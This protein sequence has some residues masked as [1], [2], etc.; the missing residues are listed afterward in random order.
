M[1]ADL[2]YF[3]L[4]SFCSEMLR[5]DKKK[6]WEF[7]VVY[8]FDNHAIMLFVLCVKYWPIMGI[9]LDRYWQA[10]MQINSDIKTLWIFMLS[11]GRISV[12]YILLK[13]M[14]WK[15]YCILQPCGIKF[16]KFSPI[17]WQNSKVVRKVDI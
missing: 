15:Q 9:E 7:N 13:D 2:G 12:Y 1:S 5:K 16:W 8:W 4:S 11:S 3:H 10:L 6:K 14:Y 17:K